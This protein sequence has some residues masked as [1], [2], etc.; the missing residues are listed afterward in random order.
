[1]HASSLLNSVK[2]FCTSQ[3]PTFSTPNINLGQTRNY[4]FSNHSLSRRY[5]LEFLC[6]EV[7]WTIFCL[8]NAPYL[9]FGCVQETQDAAP[10]EWVPS[11]CWKDLQK[12]CTLGDAD[13]GEEKCVFG[14]FLENFRKDLGAWCSSWACLRTSIDH[15]R[16]HSRQYW[17]VQRLVARRF[18]AKV[19]FWK[20]FERD[21][22]LKHFI[23]CWHFRHVTL[24]F[25]PQFARPWS[26][27]LH[28]QTRLISCSFS[29]WCQSC[30]YISVNIATVYWQKSN[31]MVYRYFHRV[32]FGGIL[33]FFF[34]KEVLELLVSC[35][36][37]QYFSNCVVV[38]F[39]VNLWSSLEW[40]TIQTASR[41]SCGSLI[42]LPLLRLKCE[43]STL[44]C[45]T[46]LWTDSELL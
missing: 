8:E 40:H 37:L 22:F 21:C 32:I 5:K 25:M 23:L 43:F 20:S 45:T 41:V 3:K 44:P 36:Y 1:M 14:E 42:V 12:L 27:A 33:A 28:S 30:F 18:V 38:V 16:P 2:Y 29:W 24:A 9:L 19:V 4:I 15:L 34:L 6:Q 10:A 11:K 13:E 35:I 39:G 46:S 7:G 31:Q 17:T 26:L